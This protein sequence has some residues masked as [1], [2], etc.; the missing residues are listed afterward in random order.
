VHTA[1]PAS[2]LGTQLDRRYR[3]DRLIGEGASA[4]VFAAQ[5]A[6]LERDVAIKVLKPRVASESDGQRRRFVAE[7]RT[8]A[9]LV[10]PHIVLVFDA[11]ETTDGLAYLVMELSTSG[12]LESELDQCQTLGAA[13]SVA[14]LLPL[15]GAL[16]CA[17]DRGVVHRDIKPANIALVRENAALRAKLL[18]FG[19]AKRP[20]SGATTDSALGTPSYMAPEQARGEALTP[21]TDVWAM[22]VVFYRCLS[23]RLPFDAQTSLATLLKLVRERAPRFA[24]ACPNLG[25]HLAVALDRALEPDRERRYADMRTFAHAIAVACV[26]DGIALPLQPD[27]LGLPDFSCWIRGTDMERTRPLAQGER[28]Q[29]AGIATLPAAGPLPSRMRM[30]PLGWVVAVVVAG[31]LTVALAA[32]DASSVTRDTS[33][34]SPGQVTRALQNEPELADSAVAA[35]PVALPLAVEP[36]QTEEGVPPVPNVRE[37]ALFRATKQRKSAKASPLP[38]PVTG[39]TASTIGAG[40]QSVPRTSSDRLIKSWEW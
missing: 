25:P 21:A 38:A 29:L 16:A 39:P 11:G 6:R 3:L 13:D 37:A 20:D 35:A 32:P 19:I 5:D 31:A 36:P 17:Q 27:P 7:A 30:R 4:W 23:G 28:V 12:N 26:Q 33:A 8:L 40:E 10:H 24:E 1:L 2:L 22:G 18:D 15:L 34:A 9:K 14:L